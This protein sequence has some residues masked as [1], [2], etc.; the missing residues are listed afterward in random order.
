MNRRLTRVGNRFGVW[1]YRVSDGRLA[2]DTKKVHVLM[3]TT[4]GRRTGLPRSTCMRYLEHEGSYLVWGTASGAPHDPDWFRNLRAS[5]VAGVRIGK[6]ELRVRA[7]ELR[8][9][10][11]DQVWHEVV[12]VQAPAVAKYAEKAGRTIPVAL[13]TPVDPRE[14]T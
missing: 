3:L 6:D 13:L 10:E 7:R 4:P 1:L 5:T 11:R 8:D 12:L 9:D 14:G 2:G